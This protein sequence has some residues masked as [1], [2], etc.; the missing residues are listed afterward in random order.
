MLYPERPFQKATAP[1][2]T[3]DKE[4]KSSSANESEIIYKSLETYQS[5][6]N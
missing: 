6:E 3:A 1:K 5:Q 2:M 4:V